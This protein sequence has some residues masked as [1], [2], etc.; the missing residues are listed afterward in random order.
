MT[1]KERLQ[2]DLK[3]AMLAHDGAR[4]TAL[5]MLKAAI[6]NAE[7]EQQRELDDEGV[8]AVL[9]RAAKQRRESIEA[10]RQGGREDLAAAEEM[11]LRL[12]EAYLPQKMDE[13]EVRA[14]VVQV[15][16][17]L[18]A[19]GPADMGRVMKHLMEKLRGR[20]DGRLVNAL[21]R[22]ALAGRK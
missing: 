15:V 4:A 2:E 19:S 16:A 3:A 20:A 8:L 5:R 1:L 11:E 21:V 6:R 10:Y 14:V 22:E 9:E 18:G 12:I 17:E 13:A 7:I